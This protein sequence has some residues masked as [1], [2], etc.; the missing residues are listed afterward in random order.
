MHFF[1]NQSIY[2]LGSEFYSGLFEHCEKRNDTQLIMDATPETL[3][4]PSRV[5]NV[6]S[7]VPGGLAQSLKM[8]VIL[9]EPISREFYL[10]NQNKTL[11]STMSFDKYAE[12]IL[13]KQIREQRANGLSRMA[14][15]QLSPWTKHFKR[16]QL[17]VLSY[18]ELEYNRNRFKWR[19][20]KFLG[21]K[22]NGKFVQDEEND[23][24][25]RQVP[26]AANEILEP[27]YWGINMELY[28]W[29]D[30]HRGP[31]MEQI[32]FLEFE[33]GNSPEVVLPNVLLIGAQFSG[34]SLVSNDKTIFD[35]DCLLL[36]RVLTYYL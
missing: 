30:L 22:L 29:L 1:D 21:K 12:Q 10:Y 18:D 33:L 7:N 2:Q 27:L 35:P 8:I 3:L 23:I 16:S 9:R 28:H 26:P 34:I 15:D 4:N 31:K 19:V 17:L 11:H 36:H 20:E 32:P 6:Y 24:L 13:K 14:V 25:A 5:H